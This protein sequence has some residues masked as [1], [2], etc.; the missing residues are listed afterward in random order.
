MSRAVVT[1]AEFSGLATGPPGSIAIEPPSA[2]LTIST[3]RVRSFVVNNRLRNTIKV[4]SPGA[5]VG[6]PSRAAVTPPSSDAPV[7]PTSGGAVAV[8]RW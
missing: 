7:V 8:Q 4:T 6:P 2:N 3:A 1:W 5:V